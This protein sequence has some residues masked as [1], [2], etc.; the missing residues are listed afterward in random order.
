MVSLIGVAPAS[1]AGTRTYADTFNSEGFSGSTG[2][3]SWASSWMESGESDGPED[4][5]IQIDDD[6][7]CADEDC[8]YIGEGDTGS[9]T[10][11]RSY[12]SS[13]ARSVELK[14]S[15]RRH[16]HGDGNGSVVLE[17]TD[18]G[19]WSQVATYDLSSKDSAQKT[20]A[21]DLTSFSSSTSAIRFRLSGGSDDSHMNIDNLT[22][23]VSLN[24][25]PVF[26]TDLGNR[27][28]SEAD[29]VELWA[30]AND[31][32]GDSLIYS[33][34]GLPSGVHID[35]ST[36]LISGNVGYSAASESPSFVTV[37]VS[38][39]YTTAIDSFQWSVED[40]NRD[41]TIGAGLSD[42]NVSEG[43]SVTISIDATDP[44][45]DSL[46]YSATG[47][48]PGLA[49]DAASGLI[50]GEVSDT[51]GSTSS[52]EV[53]VNV[54]DDKGGLDTASFN[55]AVDVASPPPAN[56][57]ATPAGTSSDPTST[58]V[59]T[60]DEPATPTTVEQAA[61]GG[62]GTATT[63]DLE[64]VS[65]ADD[66]RTNEST[67]E[68]VQSEPPAEPM[69]DEEMIEAREDILV[70]TGSRESGPAAATGHRL[71]L[72]P[73]EGL[74]VAFSSAVESFQGNMLAAIGLGLLLAGL[75]IVGIG[76]RDE[77]TDYG[78]RRVSPLRRYLSDA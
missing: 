1:A 62:E 25:P 29:S 11:K 50:S 2:T 27:T 18:G 30:A 26:E 7:K 19:S 53:V 66:V 13:N 9:A 63:Q 42:I 76:D 46:D 49:I 23:T 28:S 60:V 74:T 56:E 61:T 17:A 4:G 69:T 73:R 3:H 64:R 21:L 14:F 22:I 45:D 72:D 77:E 20:A 39:G 33:A 15:Y 43:D 10:V 71:S 8:L 68:P 34:S 35:P 32:D 52:Y 36:G 6:N 67:P 59:T 51:A 31:A 44:D 70:E 57:E 58:T 65:S 41:P 37:E 47:L 55:I 40:V 54:R 48:P 12:D 24:S 78:R 16:P 75:V 38:D 5:E